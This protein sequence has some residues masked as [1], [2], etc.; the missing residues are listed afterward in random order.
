[1]SFYYNDKK[2]KNFKIYI[3]FHIIKITIQG[4]LGEE[5]PP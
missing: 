5:C 2:Y 1:M 3:I 4:M